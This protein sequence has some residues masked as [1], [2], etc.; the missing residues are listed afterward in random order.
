MAH[1]LMVILGSAT[2]LTPLLD[3]W[4]AIRV[5]GVTLL[6]CGGESWT[7]SW[8]T[9]LGIQ[10]P[11]KV[12]ETRT[13]RHRI[14]MSV[15]D[16]E[17]VLEAAIAE[18]QRVVGGFEKPG[19]GVLLVLP[20]VRALGLH[21][22]RD[23]VEQAGQAPS[24]PP[25]TDENWTVKRDT[26]VSVVAN[27][28]DL[29]PTTVHADAPLDEVALAMLQHPAVHVACVVD[30]DRRLIGLIDLESLADHLFFHILPEDFISE[31]SDL[32]EAMEYADA[33]R[34]RT[35]ADAM[36]DPVWIRP[37]ETVRDAFRRMH[38]LRLPGLPIVDRGHHVVGYINLLEL[39]A[40]CDSRGIDD[41][42]DPS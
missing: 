11:Q 22:P 16:D 1:L 40:V 10:E 35:A 39:L 30:E 15:I 6:H 27:V 31:I 26:P 14:V 32:D 28:V 2:D 42:S 41:D 9:A 20:A 33:S 36:S 19:S 5:P 8:L 24:L 17:D 23:E 12:V 38:E 25:A 7:R 18:A 4:K 34:V 21:G 13:Q 37:D 3:A 29:E